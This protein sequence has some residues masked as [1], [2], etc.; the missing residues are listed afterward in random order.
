[1]ADKTYVFS[2]SRIVQV[3]RIK[4]RP[5]WS[6]FG[7][8]TIEFVDQWERRVISDVP[9]DEANLIM[10]ARFTKFSEDAV[11]R[12][13]LRVMGGGTQVQLERSHDWMAS[14]GP[15]VATNVAG[16][17]D[18]KL[19]RSENLLNYSEPRFVTANDRVEGRDAASSRRV[20]SH[21]GLGVAV[22]PEPTFDQGDKA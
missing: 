13:L 18:M 5:W 3:P 22:P 1:M 2:Y 16:P 11:T 21:D 20:P 4:R 7:R 10:G 17:D 19:R 12:L 9:Q 14:A 6:L 8:D 15:Y